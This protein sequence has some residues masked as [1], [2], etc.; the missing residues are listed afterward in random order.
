MKYTSQRFSDKTMDD[1]I[2]FIR[3]FGFP[4]CIKSWWI[5]LLS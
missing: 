2:S 4:N 5:K 3:E 1:K